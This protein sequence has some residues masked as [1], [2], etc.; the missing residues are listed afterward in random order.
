MGVKTGTAAMGKQHGDPPKG[1]DPAVPF[2][3]TSLRRKENAVRDSAPNICCS[4]VYVSCPRPQGSVYMY[5]PWEY[6]VA[7]KKN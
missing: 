5:I 2:L 6:Y 1:R 4:N 3:G 7:I